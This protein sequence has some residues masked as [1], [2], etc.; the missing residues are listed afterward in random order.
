MRQHAS[1]STGPDPSLALRQESEAAQMA[2]P[3]HP[4]QGA[5]PTT[6]PF[7]GREPDDRLPANHARALPTPVR[8]AMEARFARDFSM[9]RVHDDA[10]GHAAAA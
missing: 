6:S 8:T 3:G 2:R 7:A 5:V 10:V 4:S 9:V 1:R